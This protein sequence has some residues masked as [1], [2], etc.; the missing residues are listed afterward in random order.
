MEQIKSYPVTTQRW[1]YIVRDRVAGSKKEDL[2]GRT[3]HRQ[4][5]FAEDP[6][7]AIQGGPTGSAMPA[8]A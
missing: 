8:S 1:I 6:L 7:S 5:H 2:P 4:N 3:C